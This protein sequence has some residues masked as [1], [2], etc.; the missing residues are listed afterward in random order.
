MLTKATLTA[1]VD[2]NTITGTSFTGPY[3]DK[4]EYNEMG[5]TY[6]VNN[7]SITLQNKYTQTTDYWSVVA[8][9]S[10]AV[11]YHIEKI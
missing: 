9:Y 11:N 1:I 8:I 7:T 5:K 10:I 3:N 6:L 4:D 2:S